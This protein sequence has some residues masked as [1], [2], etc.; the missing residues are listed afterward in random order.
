VAEHTATEEHR[1][2]FRAARCAD[3]AADACDEQLRR[4]VEAELQRRYSHA[5]FVAVAKA[6]SEQP[7][8]CGTPADSERLLLRSHNEAVAAIAGRSLVVV[9]TYDACPWNQRKWCATENAV[10]VEAP[11]QIA[12]RRSHWLTGLVFGAAVDVVLVII[13]VKVANSP[14]MNTQGMGFSD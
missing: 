1:E 10:E 9:K 13:V 14:G 8:R 7:Q 3:V 6:C 11:G 4:D 12:A 2:S 5:D